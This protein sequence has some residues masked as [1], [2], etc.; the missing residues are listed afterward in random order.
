MTKSEIPPVSSFAVI[1][2]L[3]LASWAAS[4]SPIP[5]YRAG[6]IAREE[7]QNVYAPD[8]ADSWNRIFFCLFTRKVQ[9]R[10][11]DDFQEAKPLDPIKV[12]GLAISKGQFERIEGGDRAIEPFYP[13]HF[14]GYGQAPFERWVSPRF[15][16][17]EQALDEALREKSDRPPL[18]RA[19][20]QRKRYLGGIRPA[21]YLRR[22]TS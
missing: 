1:F 17:L 13:S 8:P 19:M 5:D 22:A 6:S 9:T 10:L 2:A 11:S 14:V 12:R 20:M 21:V 15:S 18:A 16:Q 4:Q 3:V 7:P